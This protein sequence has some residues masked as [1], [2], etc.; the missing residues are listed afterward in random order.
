MDHQL[1][2]APVDKENSS[3]AVLASATK[4][5]SKPRIRVLGDAT[6]LIENVDVPAVGDSQF[7]LNLAT[8]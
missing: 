6:S 8:S 3:T 5:W 7:P 2:K 4:E 1:K